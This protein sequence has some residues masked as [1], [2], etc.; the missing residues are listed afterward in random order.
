MANIKKVT[1][2]T[3]HTTAE[4][5]RLS[6]TYSEIDSSGNLVKSNVRESLIVLDSTIQ[7][8]IDNITVFLNTRVS[9][10]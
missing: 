5:Q 1:S 7:A 3:A 6:Y 9:E 8:D 10:S 4:G 2:F